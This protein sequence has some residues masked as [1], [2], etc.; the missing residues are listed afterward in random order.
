[1]NSYVPTGHHS[2]KLLENTLIWH[3]HNVRENTCV[4]NLLTLYIHCNYTLNLIILYILYGI[5]IYIWTSSLYIHQAILTSL[6]FQI[7]FSMFTLCIIDLFLLIS[8][9]GMYVYICYICRREV[10]VFY[11]AYSVHREQWYQSPIPYVYTHLATTADSIFTWSRLFF[12]INKL[13]IKKILSCFP[14]TEY[15]G[16]KS[17]IHNSFLN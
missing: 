13:K 5:H 16:H 1:M 10:H 11:N 9:R 14:L 7:N 4:I 12:F 3:S 2:D 6:Q 17:F 15:H 8:Y